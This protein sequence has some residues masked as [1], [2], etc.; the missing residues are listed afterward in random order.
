MRMRSRAA[1]LR[2]LA[3]SLVIGLALADVCGAVV[4]TQPAWK[5]END[6]AGSQFGWAIRTAGD[7]NGDGYDDL[8][9]GAPQYSLTTNSNEGQV[10][11]FHGSASGLSQTPARTFVGAAGARKGISVASA[12]DV[13]NDGFDDIIIGS[14]FVGLSGPSQTPRFEIYHGSA[15]GIGPTPARTVT[16]PALSELGYSVNGAGDVNNDGFDDVIVGQHDY[17]NVQSGEGR[18]SVYLGSATGIAAAPVWAVESNLAGTSFGISV[19]GAG[20]VNGDGFD[21]VI[22]GHYRFGVAPQQREGRALVY[23]GSA[24]GP[25][26]SAAWT[27]EIRLSTSQCLASPGSK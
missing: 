21:D 2:V 25:A 13:N 17:T 6:S 7:V 8:I 15:T 14:D 18:A 9:V 23:L 11:I 20:D 27:V 10:Q 4:F 1:V 19:D 3:P 12:G 26:L 16:G 24:S 22:V 5:K